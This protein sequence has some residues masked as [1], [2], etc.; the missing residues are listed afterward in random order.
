M[1]CEQFL[2][3]S[4]YVKKAAAVS[5]LLL[6]AL[7]FFSGQGAII[8]CC[9]QRT[10]DQTITLF[11]SQLVQTVPKGSD[12]TDKWG[13][14]RSMASWDER[15]HCILQLP[16]FSSIMGQCCPALL[17]AVVWNCQWARN[18]RRKSNVLFSLPNPV[19]L[20]LWLWT[21]GLTVMIPLR[22]TPHL[23]LS[24][25]PVPSGSISG[26][27]QVESR[28]LNHG[29]QRG[30]EKWRAIAKWAK[31]VQQ[32]FPSNNI[33]NHFFHLFMFLIFRYWVK[34]FYLLFLFLLFNYLYW[35][36]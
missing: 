8:L 29:V 11:A 12:S 14:E 21:S 3:S 36:Y 4:G 25:H 22:D 33:R 34:K 13:K 32:L 10:P 16:F 18:S 5:N 26:R 9:L 24:P 15:R 20:T 28:D 35:G 23:H 17:P 7:Y 1:S 6:L 30:E 27:L 19:C 31:L 2:S